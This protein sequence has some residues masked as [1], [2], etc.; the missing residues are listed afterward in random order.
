MIVLRSLKSNF[1]VINRISE[2]VK[3]VHELLI[4]PGLG[5]RILEELR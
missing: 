2:L 3:R 5:G 4:P 1:P